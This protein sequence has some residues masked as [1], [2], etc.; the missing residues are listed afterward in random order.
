METAKIARLLTLW[1]LVVQLSV[2]EGHELGAE[3]IG[4][5]RF[6]GVPSRELAQQLED[7]ETLKPRRLEAVND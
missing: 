4:F 7:S 3:H 5:R 6:H 2:D 1:R